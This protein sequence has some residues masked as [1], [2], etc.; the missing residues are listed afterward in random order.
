MWLCESLRVQTPDGDGGEGGCALGK[1][2]GNWIVEDTFFWILYIYIYPST[3][4]PLPPFPTS[5]TEACTQCADKGGSVTPSLAPTS[6]LELAL[7]SILISII[8]IPTTA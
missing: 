4:L 7:A 5:R 1:G 3:P 6:A 8:V 2:G